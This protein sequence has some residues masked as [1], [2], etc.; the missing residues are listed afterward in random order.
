MGVDGGGSGCRVAISDRWQGVI[1]ETVGGAANV[2]TDFDGA[3][4]NVRE[5]I[6]RAALMGAVS[7]EQVLAA[8]VFMGLAGVTSDA[9]A[10]RVARAMGH[11]HLTVADDRPA[12]VEGALGGGN[13]FVLSVGT[14][15]IAARNDA[16][17]LRFVGGWGFQVGDQGSAAWLGR[18][19]LEETLLAHDKMRLSSA[20]TASILEQFDRDPAA[21]VQFSLASGPAD[22]GAFAP[23]VV[24]AAEQGDD[25]G[26]LLMREGVGFLQRALSALG[27]QPGDALCLMGGVGR[28]YASY[29]DEGFTRALVAPKSSSLMGALQL[30]AR[31]LDMRAEAAS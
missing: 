21:L 29:L 18:R 14:G 6:E 20:L 25:V 8:Q 2:A 31:A 1:A 19:A 13:G 24:K 16:G 4:R 10:E 12:A 11:P 30:A 7:S 28:H 22:Y 17:V 15:T 5:G 23:S 9:V 27:Y 3:I 26:L